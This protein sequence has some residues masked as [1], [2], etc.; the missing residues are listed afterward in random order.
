MKLFNTV[1]LIAS[2]LI[3]GNSYSGN[4]PVGTMVHMGGGNGSAGASNSSL[5]PSLDY[6]VGNTGITGTFVPVTLCGGNG[7]GTAGAYYS[8]YGY[9]PFNSSSNGQAGFFVPAGKYLYLTT[10]TLTSSGGASSFVLSYNTVTQFA[11]NS[12]TVP[13]SHFDFGSTAASASG[14]LLSPASPGTSTYNLPFVF[15][16]S[17]YV[18]FKFGTSSLAFGMCAGGYLQ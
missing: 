6:P 16:P 15:P 11:E 2:L 14:G 8:L 7:S 17:V 10:E 5:Q 9:N 4:L 12:S 1:L 18:G 13:G 3:A